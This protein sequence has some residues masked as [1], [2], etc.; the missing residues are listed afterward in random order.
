LI[1]TAF[2][3][4][5]ERSELVPPELADFPAILSGLAMGYRYWSGFINYA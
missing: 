4:D 3:L 1:K 2:K 5:V